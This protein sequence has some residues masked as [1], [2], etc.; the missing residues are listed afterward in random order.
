VAS[1][2]PRG[3]ATALRPTLATGP[4]VWDQR[5]GL[6]PGP[7]G[8][9]KTWLAGA[10]GHQACREGV[11][12]RSL[13]LPRRLQARLLAT[14]EGRDPTLMTTLAQTAWLGRED[15]G[16]AAL[17]AETRR[18]RWERLDERHDRRAPLVTRPL[19]V[20]PGPEALGEPPL[21]AALRAR[22]V[23]PADKS[24]WPGDA[25]RQRPAQVPPSVGAESWEARAPA[26][27]GT[28]RT[29]AGGRGQGAEQRGEG[30]PRLFGTRGP[31]QAHQRPEREGAGVL[32]G[33][34]PG[35]QP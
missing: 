29:H 30:P 24:A 13:R 3:R 4:W 33:K 17:T 1:R 2:A 32:K 12:V 28:R 18:D 16:G 35:H 8:V 34:R 31:G 10:L 21:A 26:S 5:H 22:L 27:P 25:L 23:P 14:G 11:T 20:A 6:L 7:P 19:P 9:G 15:W